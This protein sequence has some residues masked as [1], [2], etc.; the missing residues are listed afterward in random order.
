MKIAVAGIGYVGLSNA[1]LLAQR[2]EVILTD[3]LPEKVHMIN[4]RRSPIADP[5][6]E[7]YLRNKKLSLSAR[8]H[9]GFLYREA[10]LVII[11]VPTDY[12]PG[13]G[14]FNTAAVETVID[15]AREYGGKAD[16]VIRSTVPFGFTRAANR[17]YG[18]DNIVFAPEFLREGRAL[19]D[20]LHPSRISVGGN[21]RIA[22]WFAG[23][24][25]AASPESDTPVLL[26]GSDEAEAVKLFSNA[27]LAMRIAFINELDTFAEK[28]RLDSGK[29]IEGICLDPRIGNGY[30]NPSFGY[31][32]YCL[33]KDTKQLRSAFGDIP[34]NIMSAIVDANAT[35]KAHIAE[36][37]CA[38]DAETIGIYRLA[39]KTGS[40]NFRDSSV[41][42][43]IRNLKRAGKTVVIYEP[44]L[45]DAAF[46]GC[47]VIRDL[48]DFKA[49]ADRI[50]ANRVAKDL[51]DVLER[52]YTR[53]IFGRD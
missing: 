34:N 36:S 8:L 16:I 6:A 21:P 45:K 15:A 33:P 14:F 11:A 17:R 41:L 1:V 28:N 42:D 23:M 22:K 25:A 38:L 19:Y 32:G 47:T 5:E 44:M 9:E 49:A 43:I 4:R 53:D 35:R 37:I 50:V 31:G 51:D 20:Q 40:D 18:V 30:N 3:I 10:D 13:T 26:T 24:L 39:M 52:L 48:G 27:Y 29:I 7:A 12:A 2:H 46:E